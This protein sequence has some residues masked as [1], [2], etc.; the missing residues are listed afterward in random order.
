[1]VSAASPADVVDPTPTP[2]QRVIAGLYEFRA[3]VA[4]ILLIVAL[5]F[6]SD[7]FFST[8][9]FLNVGQQVAVLSI[10]ALGATFVII[11][12][13]IDLSVGSVLALSSAVFAAMF[14]DYGFPWPLAALVGLLVGGVCGTANGLAVVYGRLPPFIAT[15]AMLSIARGLALVV[16]GGRPI[17]GFPESFR[18][19]A[20]RELPFD[21]PFS[22]ILSFL[23]FAVG[24]VVLRRT[25]FG[26]ATY[27][28]G[29]NEEA[30]RRAGIKLERQKITIYTLAGALAALGGL[31]LTARLNSAQPQAGASLELDV[32]A[33][34]VI[35]GASLSGGIGTAFG[36]LIG[37]LIIGFLR[38]GLNLLN[39]SSF[40]QQV[41]VGAVIALA[42]M[43][44]TLRRRRR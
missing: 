35:G 18:W 7:S 39:V 3:L 14:A 5:S 6:L 30:T 22:V 4:L 31:V 43:T 20:G 2:A 38:N 10:V 29:G 25:V 9:N 37:A 44:D 40:W 15:L 26:R 42:V 32:I 17:S 11:S 19:I 13:G 36:T 28:V 41:V 24:S 16:T 12:G 23:L 27:A 33:A 8:Q 21:L 34:V 1:M